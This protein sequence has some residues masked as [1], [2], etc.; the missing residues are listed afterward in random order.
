LFADCSSLESLT[1]AEGI[2]GISNNA[3]ENCTSLTSLTIPESVTFIYSHV[4]EGCSDLT[5]VTFNGVIDSSIFG[6]QSFDGDLRDK[7]LAGGGGIGTY[8][9]TAGGEVWTKQP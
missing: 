5:S 2:T 4:F 1:I 6:V 9:R 7:Y 8:T 3:F